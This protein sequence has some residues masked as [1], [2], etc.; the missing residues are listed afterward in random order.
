M[1]PA[2]FVVGVIA[3]GL[4]VSQHAMAVESQDANTG[5]K[6]TIPL[7]EIV[8]TS[9]QDGLHNLSDAMQQKATDQNPETFTRQ[10]HGASS[11][12]SNLFLVDATDL[13]DA[14]SASFT[15]LAGSQA[16]DTPAPVNKSKPK[17]GKYWL[18]A[19]L[20]SG[21]SNPTWWTVESVIVEKS[22][23][24]LTYHKTKPR[25]ATDDIRRYYFWIPLGKLTPGDYELQLFDSDKAAATLMRR[26]EV[27]PLKSGEDRK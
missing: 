13:H 5:E 10:L 6:R 11:G 24:R 4:V 16:V 19:Y 1:K 25:P 21:P 7:S 9:P 26:V 22:T 2:S 27:M 18:V 17:R 23:I 12:Y 14:L 20:G 15:V 8:T 3:I